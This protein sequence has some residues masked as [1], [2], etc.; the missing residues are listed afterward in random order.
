MKLAD[1]VVGREVIYTPWGN[2]SP[3][4]KEKGIISSSN[5]KYIFVKFYDIYYIRGL[6][7]NGT[8]CDPND[9]EYTSNE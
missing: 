3:K 9:L 7:L 4:V 8:A 5:H 6:A 2:Y 1:A